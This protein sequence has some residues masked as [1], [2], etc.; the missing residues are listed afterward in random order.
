HKSWVESADW[1][2][3]GTRLVSASDDTT[4]RIWD[5]ATSESLAVLT[6]HQDYVYDARWNKAGTTLATASADASIRLWDL[7]HVGTTVF[8]GHQGEVNG[9]AWEPKGRW[10]ASGGEDGLVQI[11]DT[12]EAESSTVIAT[13]INAITDVAWSPDGARLAF[14]DDG[15]T[16]G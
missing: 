5:V 4:V 1:S 13:R 16:V 10:L 6:G 7:T 3:D 9:L 2:P 14:I 8:S 11:S 15:G 12:T